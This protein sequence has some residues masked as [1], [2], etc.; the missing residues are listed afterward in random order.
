MEIRSY[1]SV[2]DLERRIYRVDRLRLN[3][4]GVPV[5]GV[6]YALVL[7]AAALICGKAPALQ[8]L[9]RML[10]WYLSYVALPVSCAA[11]LTVVTIDGRPFHLA[12]QALLRYRCQ[13]RQSVGLRQVRAGSGAQVGARWWPQEILVLPD[14][15]DAHMRRLRYTGPGAVLVSVAH[16]CEG[17]GRRS[18]GIGRSPV[19]LR[20]RSSAS[21][22]TGMAA[23]ASASA[24][25][26]Q[27]GGKVIAL[28]QDATL[29]IG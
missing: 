6:I 27:D 21:V 28:S 3:P 29:R 11:L 20:E 13:P 4:T 12:A 5:R 7:I 10:P 2:F 17:S 14:G 26:E 22:S 19:T 8:A 23:G 18:R 9:M 15:S 16:V 25:A 24:D 1:R